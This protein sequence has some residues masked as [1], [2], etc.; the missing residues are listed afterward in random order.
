[1]SRRKKRPKS[2]LHSSREDMQLVTLKKNNVCDIS[3]LNNI[4]EHEIQLMWMNGRWN[5]TYL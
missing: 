5:K 2:I 1:V 4:V 3:S